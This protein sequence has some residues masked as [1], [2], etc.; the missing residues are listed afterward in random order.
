M[1]FE[2]NKQTKQNKRTNKQNSHNAGNE[3]HVLS[4]VTKIVYHVVLA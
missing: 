2:T 4:Q 1:E 3:E